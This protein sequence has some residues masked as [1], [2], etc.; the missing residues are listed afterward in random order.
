M[1]GLREMSEPIDMQQTMFRSCPHYPEL[2]WTFVMV[3]RISGILMTMW[4]M[5]GLII[6]AV[7]GLSSAIVTYVFRR[8]DEGDEQI[9]DR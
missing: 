4:W 6:L 1:I 3:V 8:S 5:V 9:T 2:N 7:L